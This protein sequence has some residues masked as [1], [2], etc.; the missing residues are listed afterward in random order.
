MDID[1]EKI[2]MQIGW[3]NED[4]LNMKH[5]IVCDYKNLRVKFKISDDPN[6]IINDALKTR[7]VVFKAM[8]RFK[9][10]LSI[11]PLGG[12]IRYALE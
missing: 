4:F 10:A 3:E 6:G 1:S 7:L 11:Y 12:S 2:T 9:K 5:T 8:R